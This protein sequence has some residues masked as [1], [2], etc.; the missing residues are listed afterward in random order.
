MRIENEMLSRFSEL[1]KNDVKDADIS[2]SK[3]LDFFFDNV[4][5][6]VVNY[7]EEEAIV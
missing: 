4:M 5:N 6:S 1:R 7:F 3:E 2:I